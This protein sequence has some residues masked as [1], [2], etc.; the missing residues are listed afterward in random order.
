MFAALISLAIPTSNGG[1]PFDVRPFVSPRPAY[2]GHDVR[3]VY[4]KIGGLRRPK[5]EFESTE[6]HEEGYRRSLLK[7]LFGGMKVDSLFASTVPGKFW[8]DADEKALFGKIVLDNRLPDV[9]P[10]AP[11]DDISANYFIPTVFDDY[12]RTGT[13]TGSNAYGATVKVYEGTRTRFGLYITN[14]SRW[15]LDHGSYANTPAGQIGKDYSILV[16]YGAT[17]SSAKAQKA[18][19]GIIAVYSLVYP[20]AGTVVEQT[21]PTLDNPYKIRTLNRMLIV[22]LDR[23]LLFDKPTGKVLAKLDPPRDSE[24]EGDGT[25]L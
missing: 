14:P 4:E 2:V 13:Y 8:Y 6:E 11:R 25:H 21:K 24:T 12:V 10:G 19:L 20:Y 15:M 9:P 17:P 7:P 1:D 23:I 16:R 18:R 22:R 3:R 5:G